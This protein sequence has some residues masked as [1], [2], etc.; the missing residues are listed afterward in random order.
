VLF[1]AK[2]RRDK[3]SRGKQEAAVRLE[4]V[5]ADMHAVVATIDAAGPTVKEGWCLVGCFAFSY[6]I[7]IREGGCSRLLVHALHLLSFLLFCKHDHDSFIRPFIQPLNRPSSQ[8]SA[9]M[10]DHMDLAARAVNVAVRHLRNDKDSSGAEFRQHIEHAADV[11]QMNCV[12]MH[13]CV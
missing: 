2:S 8:V 7:Y 9:L 4:R 10:E 13:V 12:S 11:V 1:E 6:C 5:M 3:T